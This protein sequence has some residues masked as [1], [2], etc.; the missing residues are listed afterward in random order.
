MAGFPD[1]SHLN[2]VGDV[3]RAKFLELLRETCNMSRSADGAGADRSALYRQ[4]KR[5]PEFARAWDEALE[6][7]YD[8][9]EAE[10]RRRAFTGYD[11]PEFYQGQQVATKRKYSDS[12]V[13]PLLAAY[14]SRFRPAST[15]ALTGEG[16]GPVQIEAVQR[17]A[18]IAAILNEAEQ[19]RLEAEKLL[20]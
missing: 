11:E 12:L 7:A 8:E 15:V 18:R 19:R 4:R 16:G 1:L 17:V 9:L 2:E 10:A 3:K 14:R 20:E 13:M 5:D 6:A